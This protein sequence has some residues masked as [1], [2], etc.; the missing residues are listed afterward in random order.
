MSEKWGKH[1]P[2]NRVLDSYDEFQDASEQTSIL[3]ASPPFT[4]GTVLPA[5]IRYWPMEWPFRLRIGLTRTENKQTKKTPK[6]PINLCSYSTHRQKCILIPFPKSKRKQEMMQSDTLVR[7]PIYLH[8]IW[9]HHFLYGLSNVTET[10][11]D[12]CALRE[13]TPVMTSSLTSK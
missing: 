1:S 3:V 4:I 10:H 5:W 2:Y 8:L 11:V 6:N 9:L 13:H 12:A 7:F